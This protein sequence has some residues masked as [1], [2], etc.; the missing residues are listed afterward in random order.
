MVGCGGVV[1]DGRWVVLAWRAGGGGLC[2]VCV[3]CEESLG[4]G[5]VNG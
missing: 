3:C 2:C 4:L 5:F 1:N